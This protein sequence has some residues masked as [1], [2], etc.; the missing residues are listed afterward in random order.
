MKKYLLVAGVLAL[1]LIVGGCAM[2][3]SSGSNSAKAVFTYDV[4]E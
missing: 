2:Y 1:G 3:G 4:E